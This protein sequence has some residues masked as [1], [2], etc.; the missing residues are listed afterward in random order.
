MKQIQTFAIQV[1]TDLGFDETIQKVTAHLMEEG[2]GV[3]TEIDVKATFKK[4]LDIDYEPYRILGA[5]NP[6]FA[7]KALGRLPEIGVLL[8][9]NVVVRDTGKQRLVIAMDPMIIGSFTDDP[10]LK[11]IAT[12]VSQRIRR[13]LG[14]MES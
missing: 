8:P 7:H 11:S 1:E 3:L 13:V 4:K 14:K 12:E 5:C 9:C 2:F 10:E 6:T